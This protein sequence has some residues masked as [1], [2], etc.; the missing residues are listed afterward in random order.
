MH[1]ANNN[2]QTLCIFKTHCQLN[3]LSAIIFLHLICFVKNYNELAD[4]YIREIN[5]NPT[6]FED[7]LVTSYIEVPEVSALHCLKNIYHNNAI[8]RSSLEQFTFDRNYADT[9]GMQTYSMDLRE[10]VVAAYD[11]KTGTAGRS[12]GSIDVSVSWLK[13]LLRLRLASGSFAPNHTGAGGFRSFPASAWKKLKKLVEQDPGATLA[14]LLERSKVEASIM[15]VFRALER[16]DCRLKKS[17]STL[18]KQD[19]PMSKPSA[20]NGASRLRIRAGAVGFHRRERSKNHM[21]RLYGRAFGGKRRRGYGSARS[22]CTTTMISALRFD[23][24]TADM[25]LDGATDGVAFMVMSG[26]FSYPVCGRRY[27]G[28]GQPGRTQMPAIIELIAASGAEVRFLPPYSPDFNPMRKCGRK[29]KAYLRKV[30][31]RT[32]ESLWQAIGAALKTV[33]ASTPSDGSNL[34]L[35][36]NVNCSRKPIQLCR[37]KF[38]ERSIFIRLYST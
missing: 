13:K 19:R 22:L 35:T 6:L 9:V 34:V 20:M 1:G 4:R 8:L 21:T 2:S 25:V 16:L 3:R 23:A 27:C 18:P 38:P 17:R 29:I 26:T 31:A 11:G 28:D 15:A 36:L 5:A 33:T 30:K 14:E 32:K 24:S 12:R 10:R 7:Q 37:Q